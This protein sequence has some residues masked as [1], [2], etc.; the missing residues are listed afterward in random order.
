[1]NSSL[2]LTPFAFPAPA[3]ELCP[4]APQIT[5][6]VELEFVLAVPKSKLPELDDEL[7]KRLDMMLG[8]MLE[9]KEEKQLER[10]LE[11]LYQ[12]GLF[13]YAIDT[14][15]VQPGL[16]VTNSISSYKDVDYTKWNLVQ[17][18]SIV[19]DPVDAAEPQ[20]QHM[21]QVLERPDLARTGMELVSPMFLFDERE[22]WLRKFTQIERTLRGMAYTEESTGFHVHL[23]V[24]ST[25]GPG[26]ELR[27]V[28]ALALLWASAESAIETLHPSHRHGAKNVW[29]QSLLSKIRGSDRKE[30]LTTLA[31]HLTK[32][33]T[34]PD[35]RRVIGHRQAK[36]NV[37]PATPH[38]LLT[39][40][41]REATGT[42]SANEIAQWVSFCQKM[43]LH[44]IEM[45]NKV[46]WTEKELFQ[47]FED[48]KDLRNLMELIGVPERD[49]R[50]LYSRASRFEEQYDA[51][52]EKL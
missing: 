31:Y 10:E 39:V 4:T 44:A 21:V 6:G 51:D 8:K 7:Q 23:G 35:I 49:R 52:F 30:R 15:N 26:L 16:I 36:V 3:A 33:E 29:C 12:E 38:K 27:T 9:R 5:F 25:P 50:D 43:L 20:E 14:L 18:G 11:D 13:A 42:L 17:D 34:V 28:K 24:A 46:Q 47:L 22:Y 45:S 41:F 32:A 2:Q 1:M 19:A 37:S 40:E 48:T